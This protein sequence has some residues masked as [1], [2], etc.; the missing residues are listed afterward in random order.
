[1]SLVE[2]AVIVPDVQPTGYTTITTLAVELAVVLVVIVPVRVY[3]AAF[4]FV[5]I[6]VTCAARVLNADTKV[7]SLTVAVLPFVSV[8]V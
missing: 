4:T 7:E 6:T 8:K 3:E 1:M 5:F 2:G